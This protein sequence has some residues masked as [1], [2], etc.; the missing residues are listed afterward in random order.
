MP[1]SAIS[2]SRT[3]PGGSRAPKVQS[4][5]I[6]PRR[7]PRLGSAWMAFACTV[8]VF[9]TA[10][11]QAG[12]NARA[13]QAPADFLE[14]VFGAAPPA[15]RTLWPTKA[16]REEIGSILGHPLA[17]L[18]VR[19]WV[20][21]ERYIFVLDE[22]GKD[23]PITTAVIVTAGRIERVKVLVFRESRGGE[24]Q[25]AS[26]TEQFTGARLGAGARLDRDIDG[27]TG[28]TLSVRAVTCQARL[29]LYLYNHVKE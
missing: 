17:A 25:N 27:I 18:R 14:G 24:V 28:A 21:D 13:G 1:A 19:Y 9:V 11:G 10:A 22:I 26:F 23:K 8:A 6:A 20:R 5:A 29:G 2:S 4:D 7:A 3:A 16:M 15:A 12:D